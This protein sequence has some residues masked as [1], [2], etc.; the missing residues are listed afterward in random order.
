MIL[1]S[2]RE[3][4]I[5]H[6]YHFSEEFNC[7][8]E[9]IDKFGYTPEDIDNDYSLVGSMDDVLYAM[10]EEMPGKYHYEYRDSWDGFVIYLMED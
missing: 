4:R 9:I 2:I 10:L 8:Q 1:T 3:W 5:Q 7:R 6:V